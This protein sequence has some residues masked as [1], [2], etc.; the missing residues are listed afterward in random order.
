[1]AKGFAPVP[2]PTVSP[3]FKRFKRTILDEL[4]GLN[5]PRNKRKPKHLLGDIVTIAILATLGGADNMVAV[6][7]Y[8]REKQ[9]WLASFLELPYGIL[10]HDILLKMITIARLICSSWL[11]V[12]Y[13]SW[14]SLVPV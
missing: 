8:G 14:R 9:D 4:K 13:R 11:L 3:S 12:F 2:P 1:M 5:D 6:E 10:S 7:T